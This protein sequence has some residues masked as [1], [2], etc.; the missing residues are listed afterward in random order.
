VTDMPAAPSSAPPYRLRT[1]GTFALTGPNEGTVLGKH[2][3]QRRRLALLAVLAAAGERGRSRDQLLLLFW[4]DATQSRARHSLEQLLYAIRSSIDES[5]FAGTNPV[6]LDPRVVASDVDDFKGALERGDL[7]AAVDHYAGRFLD[8]FYLA[9]SPEFEQWLDGERARFERSYS[10]ALEKLAQSADAAGDRVAAVRWWQKLVETDPVSSRNATGLMRAHMNAGDDASALRYAERYESVVR[11]ELGTEAGPAIAALIAEARGKIVSV[12]TT[13]TR[14]KAAAP[15]ATEE[16]L[17]VDES[18]GLSRL[19]GRAERFPKRRRPGIIPYVTGASAIVITI[20]GAVLLK[21]ARDANPTA[22]AARTSTASPSI[23][24]LPF[25]NVSRDQ[26]DAALVDGITEELIVVLAK[27]RNLRVI[28]RTSAFAF[29]DTDRTVRSIADSLG[30]SN[31]LEGSVQKSGSRI[32]VQ[33]RL[34]DHDGS[35]RWSETYDRELKDIFSVQSDIAGA[36][37]KEL[38]LRLSESAIAR[39]RRG[40]TRNLAAYELYLRGNDPAL[41]RG[42]SSARIALEY[43]QQAIALDSK[44]A[45]AHAG[46]ARMLLR[47]SSGSEPGRSRRESILL[48]EKAALE[49]L[50]LDDSSAEAH[51]T[52]G[53]VRRSNY[54][55]TSAEDQLKRAITLDPGSSRLREWLTQLYALTDRP[56]E[57]LVEARRAVEL[58]P[59]SPSAHAEVAHALLANNRCDE[60][61]MELEKLKSVRP[62]LL[63]ASTIAAH[64]YARKKMWPEAIAELPRS[65]NAGPRGQALLGYFLARSGRTPEAREILSAMVDRHRRIDGGAFEVALVYAGLGDT[66]QA[67]QWLEKAIE[68]RSLAFDWTQSGIEELRG[69]P[70]FER[71]RSRLGLQSR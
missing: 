24:V 70:R 52:L 29:R 48:A 18:D 1:L 41:I 39:I 9:D 5:V 55:F 4:P 62:P 59:F 25:V 7:E 42:D 21:T 61:L 51:A 58:D 28:G 57:A 35:T 17:P 54:Q 65:R 69:D 33:V 34:V 15:A 16:A 60:A 19:A 37:S 11:R 43:F 49:A 13:P 71:I 27:I 67:F 32:R 26:N 46:L 63:R 56:A 30:V 44:F 22:S 6:R 14:Q 23:A 38:D 31:I 66:D 20:A 2:G 8:G 68:D 10:V 45:A 36:V 40:S 3:Q 50:S 12:P 64:C 53:L 47:T